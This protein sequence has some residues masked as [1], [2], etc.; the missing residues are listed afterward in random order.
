VKN[1]GRLAGNATPQL[2]IQQPASAGQPPKVMRGFEKVMLQAGQSTKV[3]FSLRLK[4]ISIW[5]TPSAGWKVPS[6]QIIAYV[7]ES[8]RDLRA[9]VTLT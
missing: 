1:T 8:S 5:D 2:Y 6:G 9:N 4:D 3:Q 7:G